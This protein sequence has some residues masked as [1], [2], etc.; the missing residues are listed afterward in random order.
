MGSSP[1]TAFP[2]KLSLR[3]SRSL[4][5]SF[6]SSVGGRCL[7]SDGSTSGSSKD[8]WSHEAVECVYVLEG[9]LTVEVD[10]EQLTV[11]ANDSVTF[12]SNLPHRYGNK[13]EGQVTFLLS[14]SPPTP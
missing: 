5:A 14:V 9:T 10:S 13:H 4:C 7:V 2:L 3:K 11:V 12:S 8:A 6:A 1:F